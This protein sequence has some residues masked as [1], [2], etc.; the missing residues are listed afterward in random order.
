MAN[1]LPYPRK[2]IYREA[3]LFTKCGRLF[4]LV[5]LVEVQML[6]HRYNIYPAI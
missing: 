5:A 4:S 3:V 2:V 6:L 1:L